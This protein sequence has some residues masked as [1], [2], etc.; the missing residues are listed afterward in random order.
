MIPAAE[1]IQEPQDV[2]ALNAVV[3][4]RS[5]LFRSFPLVVGG[6]LAVL[7]GLAAAVTDWP[8]G[9]LWPIPAAAALGFGVGLPIA[10][11]VAWLGERSSA[12]LVARMAWAAARRDGLVGPQRV[13]LTPQGLRTTSPKGE[14]LTRWSGVQEVVRTQDHVFVFVTRNTAFMAPRRAFPS[15]D[16]FEAFGRET[17]G[18]WREARAN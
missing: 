17:E 16:A 6:V 3:T 11:V 4:G 13:E 9:A 7:L 10:W 18:Q 8:G 5:R 12:R 15:A 14:T 1:F 2:L